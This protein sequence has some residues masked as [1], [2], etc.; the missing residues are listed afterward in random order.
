MP[1]SD[2]HYPF[3]EEC[4]H[5]WL[6]T[7][8]GEI[9]DYI[10]SGFSCSQHNT[11]GEGI[12]HLRPMNVSPDGD[13]TLENTLYVPSDA[14]RNRLQHGDVLFTNTSSTVLVGKTASVREPGEWAFSNHMT[15]LR[16]SD[17]VISEFIARQLHYLCLSG[18][19]AFHCT[20]HINQSS[21]SNKQLVQ[22][23]FRL[24]PT[25]EQERIANKLGN[26]LN[27]ELRIRNSLESLLKLVDTCRVSILTSACKGTLVTSEAVL[28]KNENRGYENATQLLSRVMKQRQ[29]AWQHQQIARFKAAGKEPSDERWIHRY[30]EPIGSAKSSQR[31]R[32]PKGWAWA[33]VDQCGL[34][35]LGRMRS[36][37][38]RPKKHPR[39]YLRAAN[40]TENGLDLRDVMVMD[41]PPSEFVQYKLEVGDLLVAEASGSPLQV[42]KPVIW[43][44]EIPD[45][46]YQNTVIRLRPI[47][48]NPEFLLV[49]MQYFYKTGLFAEHSTGTGI[50]HL[51][52]DR[53][54]RIPVALPPLREQRRIVSEVQRRFKMLEGLEAA[55][56]EGLKQLIDLKASFYYQAFAGEL[57]PHQ[58][59]A[60]T[61]ATLLNNIK[62]GSRQSRP[63]RQRRAPVKKRNERTKMKTL[64]DVSLSYLS[65][66]LREKKGPL[67]ARALWK[68]SGLVIDDFYAQLKREMDKSVR[69][70]H[71]RMLELKDEN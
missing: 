15:R 17:G 48:I 43:R 19:F 49:V 5:G 35:Q 20:K 41:F 16:P 60:E 57:V 39:R 65:E 11:Q 51:S 25:N 18:Y 40:I 69:E 7:T 53:F 8:V 47:V 55:I 26:L 27:R 29:R 14:G 9:V 45:C 68:E 36:P 23:P 31:S 6:H 1:I 4:P 38:N 54:I 50:N 70:T 58:Q 61:A 64:Q 71:D 46:C 3:P 62:Q 28:A 56:R 10:E 66:I 44:G 37:K 59:G 42:G 22:I 30:K 24:A 32:L 33:S 52:A 67:T 12:P 21:I 13:V 2:S 63:E 34:V